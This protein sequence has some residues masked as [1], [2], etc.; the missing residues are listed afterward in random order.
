MNLNSTQQYYLQT[1]GL[2]IYRLRANDVV[3]VDEN[4]SPDTQQDKQ[5]TIEMPVHWQELRSEVAACTR[6]ELHKGRTQTVFGVPVQSDPVRHRP[7]CTRSRVRYRL[8]QVR[9]RQENPL[10][11]DRPGLRPAGQDRHVR[12]VG[13]AGGYGDQGMKAIPHDD[14]F[15]VYFQGFDQM[16]EALL[17]AAFLQ[18]NGETRSIPI[19][20]RGKLV[21]LKR[22]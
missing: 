9:R 10:D 18:H 11:P 1:M 4:H 22:F 19:Y 3:T 14:R 6:C 2:D 15:Y 8:H 7:R 17:H 16:V 12:G 21:R 5:V 13:P 20:Q